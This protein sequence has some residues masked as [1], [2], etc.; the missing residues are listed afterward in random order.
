MLCVVQSRI[1]RANFS[2]ELIFRDMCDS[3]RATK[4]MRGRKDEIRL[5]EMFLANCQ[6]SLEDFDIFY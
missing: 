5:I 3:Y 6:K 1:C 2:K 4:L